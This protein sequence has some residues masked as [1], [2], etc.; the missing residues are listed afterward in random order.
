MHRTHVFVNSVIILSC[1]G[2]LKYFKAQSVSMLS[3]LIE[4]AR[5]GG[6]PHHTPVYLIVIMT[7]N[8]NYVVIMIGVG[9]LYMIGMINMQ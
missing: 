2:D 5:L 4:L 8:I 3:F 9:I 6:L 7:A 1:G